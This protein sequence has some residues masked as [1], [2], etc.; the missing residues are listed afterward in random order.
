MNLLKDITRFPDVI[1]DAAE[2]YE[3]FM[4]SRFAVSVAQ[5]LISSIMTVRLMLMMKM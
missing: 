1:K 4:I 2:K 3:P 5:H